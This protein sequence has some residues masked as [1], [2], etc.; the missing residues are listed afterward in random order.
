M[1]ALREAARQSAGRNVSVSGFYGYRQRQACPQPDSEV[2]LRTELRMLHA[3]SRGTYGRPRRVR[4]LRAQS[5]AVGHRR[6]A[7]LMREE[8][9]A[10]YETRTQA[11]QA[12]A[13]T[14]HGFYNPMRIHSTLNYLSPNDF[15]KYL[16]QNA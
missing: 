6:V 5:H 8:A 16:R 9:T 3:S 2:M 1:N 12:I 4:G 11:C 15:A 13:C 10:A 14:I 7:R